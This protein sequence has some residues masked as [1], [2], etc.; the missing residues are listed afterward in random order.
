MSESFVDKVF[1]GLINDLNTQ[2]LKVFHEEKPAIEEKIKGL[3]IVTQSETFRSEQVTFVSPSVLPMM[4][5]RTKFL[6]H[7]NGDLVA[8]AV[9][10]IG[11]P[12]R[13]GTCI[14]TEDC[15]LFVVEG[16]IGV[17]SKSAYLNLSVHDFKEKSVFTPVPMAAALVRQHEA[18][19]TI[20][21]SLVKLNKN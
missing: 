11:S 20:R 2:S 9:T 14:M 3:G 5:K 8:I 21:G 13:L 18:L 16:P 1:L 19:E 7:A 17:P 4:A 12:V 6:R 15:E 10:I